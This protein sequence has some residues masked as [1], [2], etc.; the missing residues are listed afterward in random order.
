MSANNI[1]RV[2]IILPEQGYDI[3][4]DRSIDWLSKS[5][6]GA[7]V[8]VCLAAIPHH[9]A[10]A[11]NLWISFRFSPDTLAPTLGL[12]APVSTSSHIAGCN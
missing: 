9:R 4:V 7:G 11:R 12:V 8:D 10:H 5:W 3:G 1:A 6:E 2:A